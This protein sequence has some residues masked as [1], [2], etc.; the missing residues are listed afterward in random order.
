MKQYEMFELTYRHTAPA[1]DEVAVDL[2]AEFVCGEEK[3]YVKGFY[4]GGETYKIRFLPMHQGNYSYKVSGILKDEGTLTAEAGTGHGPVRTRGCHFVCADG[5]PYAP[6]GTT[7]YALAH[8]EKEITEQTFA[9]LAAS[10]F[11]KVRLCLFPKHYDFNENEPEYYPFEKDKVGEWDV[12]RP[13]YAFWDA[14]E[15]KLERLKELG[16]EADLILLHSY[17]RWGFALLG[18]EKYLVYLEYLLRRFAA[19][20]HIWWSLA[21]EYDFVRCLTIADW[22]K[23]ECFVAENDPYHHLLSNHNCF[24]FWDF[25]RENITHASIQTRILTRIADWR[26]KYNKPVVIDECCY[27]GNL[28]QFWGSISGEEMV[29]RFWQ[30]V[31]T[32]GYCT[33]GD[34]FLDDH[35]VI[36]WAKG[37]QIRGES[38]PRIAFLKAIVESLP[39]PIDP[40]PGFLEFMRDSDHSPEAL[41]RIAGTDPRFAAFLEAFHRMKPDEMADFMDKEKT[42][43][44]H[45][46]EEAYLTFYDRRTCAE[47]TLRLPEDKTYDVELIDVW[48]MTRETIATGVSGDTRVKLP[49]KEGFA[50]LAR[51][52]G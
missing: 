52:N 30:V 34:T 47:D 13:C 26:R 12:H 24:A 23:I 1:R 33:H 7:V 27:E 46:G 51:R 45:V 19:Y 48:N 42:F 18:L 14:F 29:Y 16:I 37:G 11:N 5:T 3:T 9:T 15:D 17:D 40:A 43:E 50:V 41:A 36:W 31:A 49:G 8:Q 39:G 4:A 6:F 44:G 35:D 22:E 32:G 10:P 38:V 28:P 25:T 20:P 2:R 21:N